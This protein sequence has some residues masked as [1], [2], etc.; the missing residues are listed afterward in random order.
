VQLWL[1]GH[2]LPLV[3]GPVAHAPWTKQPT[4]TSFVYPADGLVVSAGSGSLR[5][6]SCRDGTGRGTATIKALSL[7]GGAVK[8]DSLSL[9][10]DGDGI[11]G[12]S[13]ISGLRID[14]VAV[15]TPAVGRRLRIST[16]GNLI[17]FRANTV[18]LH[19]QASGP[20]R[21]L[22]AGGLFVHVLTRHDGV[23]AG[24]DVVVAFAD[25]RLRP[26]PAPLSRSGGTPSRPPAP[27]ATPPASNKKTSKRSAAAALDSGRP[28]TVTP[29]LDH[30]HFFFPVVGDVSWG[31]NY[32][33]FRPDVQGDWHHGDDLFARLGTPVVAVATGT[34]NRVGWNRIGGWRL[35]VRDKA[36]DEFYY[37][38]LAG[39]T[40][41]ALHSKQVTA[42]EVIG[43]IGNT[44]DALPT[45]PHIDFEIHPRSLL[46]LQYDGAVD[47]TSYLRSW[48]L[49]THVVAPHPVVP[50]ISSLPN[51]Q[52]RHEA[53]VIFRELLSNRGLL[54]HHPR[55]PQTIPAPA[56]RTPTPRAPA[57]TRTSTT[58]LADDTSAK[59][60]SSFNATP[61]AFVFAGALL[62]LAAGALYRRRGSNAAATLQRELA[63]ADEIDHIEA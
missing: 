49:L 58:R 51:A 38:H 43:F 20:L 40:P 42:G 33:A 50:T 12:T 59:T 56:R 5:V 14:G 23:P 60:G 18:T 41:L 53:S 3:L 30:Q 22:R 28:L 62:L 54:K 21:R 35:W 25:L 37:A 8:A 9:Q 32:G 55:A 7:F 52:I 39:Y 24:T 17:V 16:W 31:D 27:Q 57:A 13:S 15:P 11:A 61:I 1:P 45:P 36:G 47:P 46:R 63:A 34:L 4:E 2:T 19:A 29:P 44:G 48:T 10:I 6:P 26:S